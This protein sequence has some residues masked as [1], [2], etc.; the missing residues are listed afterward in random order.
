MTFEH[1][2]TEFSSAHGSIRVSEPAPGVFLSVAM[3]RATSGTAGHIIRFAEEML[4]AGRRLLVFHDWEGLTGYDPEARRTLTEWTGRI[5]PFWDGSHILLA[6]RLVAMAISVASIAT[7]PGKIKA[8][9]SRKTWEAALAQA[10]VARGGA[11]TE[12][13]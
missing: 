6:S 13:R 3:G 12:R 1:A 7:T 10:C 2:P 8:Y 5:S 9:S 4:A 11:T